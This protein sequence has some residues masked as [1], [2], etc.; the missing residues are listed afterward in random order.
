MLLPQLFTDPSTQNE[1]AD[2][3]F[4]QI[5]SL[6]LQAV[7]ES[8]II[9]LAGFF[10][11]KTKLLPTGGQRIISKL[12][13]DLFT[14]CLLF[15]KL[16]SSLSIDKIA[17]IVIIPIFY[18]V[19]TGM[20]YV[21]S[22]LSARYLRLN[23]PESDFVTAMAVFGNSNSLPVSLT[24][25]LSY[26]LPNLFWDRIDDDNY[27]KVASRGIL[28]LLIF[29]QL[30]QIL[31]WSWGFN[32]LLRKRSVEEMS[33]HYQGQAPQRYFDDPEANPNKQVSL[34]IETE[35]G[36][37]SATSSLPSSGSTSPYNEEQSAN[38]SLDE[39][40]AKT[41]QVSAIRAKWNAFTSWR[42]VANFLAFMNPPL[43]AMMVAIFIASV[44]SLQKLFFQE[45][46]VK[47]TITRSILNLGDTSIPLILIVLG[48][49]LCPSPDIPPATRNYNK[50]VF[51][52][53]VSRMIL[54]SIV[55]LPLIALC[56][57]FINISILDDPI[58]LIVAF[59][60]TMSPPAVQL[61]QITQLN[62]IY[63]KEMAGVLFWGYVIL[64]LPATIFIVVTSLEVL[65]WAT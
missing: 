48:S 51:A 53:L 18:A 7:L 38:T 42:P 33:L 32:T 63:Q 57:K 55:M 2:L 31:R 39:D 30:G 28:Y 19:S 52:S 5:S 3:S 46:F 15:T 37:N 4:L 50:I 47:N 45:S 11:A 64:T 25:S 6:T 62:N 61:S 56:V 14:P 44:P 58:F 65:K 49:N 36:G 9:C 12:N 41:Y 60:L 17:N 27:D 23:E 43:Y 24:M 29:Q 34:Y 26:T 8:V 54:P 35:N 1:N 10:A 59:I 21:C 13:V 40:P 20:S 22:R 16:A